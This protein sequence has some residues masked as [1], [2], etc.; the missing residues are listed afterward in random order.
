VLIETHWDDKWGKK[1]TAVYVVYC[2][3]LLGSLLKFINVPVFVQVE[4]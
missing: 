1:N 2:N 4:Q 3:F